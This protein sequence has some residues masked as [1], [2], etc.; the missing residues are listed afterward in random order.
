MA[1]DA[2]RTNTSTMKHSSIFLLYLIQTTKR[3]V[4]YLGSGSLTFG[5]QMGV[6]LLCGGLFP[7]LQLRRVKLHNWRYIGCGYLGCWSSTSA[8][9]YHKWATERLEALFLHS[10]TPSIFSFFS[11]LKWH[12][13]SALYL[14]SFFFPHIVCTLASRTHFWWLAAVM[15]R[16]DLAKN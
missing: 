1:A 2:S 11:S 3:Y 14:G 13:S 16:W 5:R 9:W 8:I 10:L 4:F 15:S 6:I 7:L 12:L